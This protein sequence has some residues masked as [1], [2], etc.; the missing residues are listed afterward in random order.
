MQFFKCKFS[1]WESPSCN[2][3]TKKFIILIKLSIISACSDFNTIIFIWTSLKFPF[4]HAFYLTNQSFYLDQIKF[5]RFYWD[6]LQFFEVLNES[7]LQSI[8]GPN[9][10]HLSI[11]SKYIQL[12]QRI[13]QNCIKNFSKCFQSYVD[14]EVSLLRSEHLKCQ[15]NHKATSVVSMIQGHILNKYVEK[16]IKTSKNESKSE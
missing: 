5:Y 4:F 12:T 3:A 2:T 10:F 16:W 1:N 11:H 13:M 6:F 9:S 15:R 8:F 14:L 7:K